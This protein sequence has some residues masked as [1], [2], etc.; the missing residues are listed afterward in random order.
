MAIEPAALVA[1]LLVAFAATFR[2]AGQIPYASAVRAV[3]VPL[4]LAAGCWLLS[5]RL[6]RRARTQEYALV[7]L[8]LALDGDLARA[9]PR[10]MRR[11]NERVEAR[12]PLL[13]LGVRD[14]L[15]MARET[16][17]AP[18]RAAVAW[19]ALVLALVP[20]A[21][22]AWQAALHEGA[23]SL[24]AAAVIVPC[25]T[26]F[27][28]AWDDLRQGRMRNP[29]DPRRVR[30]WSEGYHP[31]PVPT[32]LPSLP[33][34]L[35]V[36]LPAV[37][38]GVKWTAGSLGGRLN[39][40]EAVFGLW[41]LA[42]NG[43]RAVTTATFRRIEAL[44][45]PLDEL[46]RRGVTPVWDALLLLCRWSGWGSAVLFALAASWPAARHSG[47]ASTLTTA[48]ATMLT[49]SLILALVVH[50]H[51]RRPVSPCTRSAQQLLRD[52]GDAQ[53]RRF[54][55]LLN[56]GLGTSMLLIVLCGVLI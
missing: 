38:L 37:L 5:M 7:E 20:V 46:I 13:Q 34:L 18:T 12:T 11:A 41:L 33:V 24:V 45:A 42:W 22:W 32:V 44:T 4:A 16:P 1:L 8:L 15:E 36:F 47:A 2:L 52:L 14:A 17:C 10:R 9:F 53:T 51:L 39:V 50:S 40:T 21:G 28:L 55:T 30:S 6:E 43:R 48:S 26:L 35:L 29:I 19:V 25:S 49:L 54:S 23:V 3:L 56:V 31:E 27:V